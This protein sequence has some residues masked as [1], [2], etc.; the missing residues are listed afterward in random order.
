MTGAG[1]CGTPERFANR[2]PSAPVP[3]THT[4][5]PERLAAL[6]ARWHS[7]P[8]PAPG[9]SITARALVT[10]PRVLATFT[11]Y[12]D[13][14]DALELRPDEAERCDHSANERFGCA[15]PGAVLAALV[16]QFD[17]ALAGRADPV[18]L[19]RGWF[20]LEA[21]RTDAETEAG[22]YAQRLAGESADPELRAEWELRRAEHAT[23]AA[24]LS[25]ALELV[26][27][28]ATELAVALP[29]AEGTR[30]RR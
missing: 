6:R 26:G 19:K 25:A 22:Q 2:Q 11:R 7:E 18:V 16:D 8:L 17:A 30:P 21:L 4:P 27:A 29:L 12:R 23:D 10:D 9:E 24:Q 1:A 3:F 28:L 13:E 5:K 14:A 20:I 15:E